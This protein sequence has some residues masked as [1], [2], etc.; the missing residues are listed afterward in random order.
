MGGHCPRH[1]VSPAHIDAHY[2]IESRLFQLQHRHPVLAGAGAGV[3]D[4]NVDAP[5][6]GQGL[7]HHIGYLR[8][9]GNVGEETHGLPPH[10]LDF[11]DHAGEALPALLPVG[12]ADGLLA[13]ADV[14]HH[15]VGALGGQ[16]G[17]DGAADAVPPAGPGHQ[18]NF[19]VQVIHFPSSAWPAGGE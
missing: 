4:Q 5:E 19:P 12:R 15:H 7:P 1:Q 11:R 17:S 6:T 3:V 9:V 8:P 14:G 13:L 2:L 10:S 16:A 18:R